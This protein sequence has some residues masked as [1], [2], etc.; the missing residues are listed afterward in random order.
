MSDFLAFRTMVTPVIIQIIF[1]VGVACC[2]TVGV[3]YLIMGWSLDN[4]ANMIKGL[5]VVILGPLAVRIYCEILIVIF[6][7]NETLTEIKHSL[8][9]G[10]PPERE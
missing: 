8:E 1:W 7:I 2:L 3:V 9:R 4:A 5:L 10:R 6:R